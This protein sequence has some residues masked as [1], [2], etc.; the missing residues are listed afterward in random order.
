MQETEASENNSLDFKFSLEGCTRTS[1]SKM[2]LCK[3]FASFANSKGGYVIF[4]IK[5]T[6]REVCGD[7]AG[8]EFITLLEQA[9][10]EIRPRLDSASYRLEQRFK[11]SELQSVF[12]IRID[13]SSPI[14]KP[15]V[16][17]RTIPARLNGC[18]EGVLSGDDVRRLIGDIDISSLSFESVIRTISGL[19]EIALPKDLTFLDRKTL[20]DIRIFFHRKATVETAFVV[21]REAFDKLY[22]ALSELQELKNGQ[23]SPARLIEL[24]GTAKEFFARFEKEYRLVTGGFYS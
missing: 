20:Q 15:H 12:F 10:V 2:K 9:L 16:V 14:L 1:D 4:G 23:T 21:V 11:V 6:P 19:N 3:C 17:N 7:A 18:S 24:S 22:G 13:Q 5:D 8:D